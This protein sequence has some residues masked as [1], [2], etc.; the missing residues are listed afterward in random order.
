MHDKST[1]TKIYFKTVIN[2]KQPILIINNSMILKYFVLL[3]NIQFIYITLKYKKKN[4]PE[5]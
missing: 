2:Y 4:R 5:Y 3:I 1:K